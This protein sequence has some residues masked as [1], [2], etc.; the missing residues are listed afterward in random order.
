MIILNP[1]TDNLSEYDIRFVFK[2]RNYAGE[3]I[4]M[5]PHAHFFNA[6]MAAARGQNGYR[7]FCLGGAVNAGKTYCVLWIILNIAQEFPKCKIHIVRE[8]LT[9]LQST[10][11]ES[12]KKQWQGWGRWSMSVSNIFFELPNGSRIH[13]FS[14]SYST[15]KDLDRWKGLETNIIFLEQIEELQNKTWEKALER[16]GRWKAGVDNSLFRYEEDVLYKDKSLYIDVIQKHFQQFES[17]ENQLMPQPIIFTTFNPTNVLWVRDLVYTPFKTNKINEKFYIRYI[18]PKDNPFVT[19]GEHEAWS[20]MSEAHRRQFIE[21]DWNATNSIKAYAEN[22]NFDKHVT[23]VKQDPDMAITLSFDFN[24]SPLTCIA[25]HVSKVYGAIYVFKEFVMDSAN[26]FDFCSI[27]AKEVKNG[28][29]IFIT[30]D[31]SGHQRTIALKD[32]ATY[33][34]AIL[35]ALG[36]SNIPSAIKTPKRNLGQSDARLIMNAMLLQQDVKIDESCIR[37]IEDLQGVE[38]DEN[39]KMIKINRDTTHLLDCFKYICTTFFA[40][41]LMRLNPYIYD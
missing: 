12:A 40:D 38:I 34:V 37:L 24:V 28:Q 19:K 36:L 27:I 16:V 8:T 26:I 18:L 9:S 2:K 21:G 15:D 5:R 31:A 22:F 17:P 13:F 29:P 25:S 7:V 39:G 3:M 20:L 35:N 32:N 4:Y 1:K 33:Y 6:A 14:E 23:H 30:G 11:I 10:T 41:D